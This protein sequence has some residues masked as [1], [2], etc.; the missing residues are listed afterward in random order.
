[1]MSMCLP[2]PTVIRTTFPIAGTGLALNIRSSSRTGRPRDRPCP[3]A[4][5][6]RRVLRFPACRAAGCV[7]AGCVAG[8][9]VDVKRCSA[10]LYLAS[11]PARSTYQRLRCMP[12]RIKS[13]EAYAENHHADGHKARG[14]EPARRTAESVQRVRIR[15]RTGRRLSANC[16]RLVVLRLRTLPCVVCLAAG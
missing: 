9:A 4:R 16:T 15:V 1:M 8:A 2:I 6:R 5:G 3:A 7:V 12:G 11:R 13:I 14:T 10:R